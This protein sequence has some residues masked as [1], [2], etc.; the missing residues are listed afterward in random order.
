MA[1]LQPAHRQILRESPEIGPHFLGL[2]P[3]AAMLAQVSPLA[4]LG[5]LVDMRSWASLLLLAVGFQGG[6]ELQTLELSRARRSMAVAV[7]VRPQATM[8]MR[9][10]VPG[11]FTAA[12]AAGR[13]T[14]HPRLTK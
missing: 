12:A 3:M 11:R 6:L 14:A 2:F 5:Q 1:H 4:L 13:L 10:K 8:S 7:A 9:A